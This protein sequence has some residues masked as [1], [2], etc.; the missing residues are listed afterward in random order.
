[1]DILLEG[2]PPWKCVEW[3]KSP[4]WTS[5]SVTPPIFVPWITNTRTDI[6]L[7]KDKIGSLDKEHKWELAKKMVNP[8]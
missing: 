3:V 4:H 7:I 8:S 5:T 1:M 2:T 6:A